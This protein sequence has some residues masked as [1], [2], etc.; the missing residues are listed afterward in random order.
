M[1]KIL[2]IEDEPTLRDELVLILTFEGYD[3]IPAQDGKSGIE[4]A[5]QHLPNLILC[6]VTM[7]RLDG[8]AVFTQLRNAPETRNIP[9]VLMT[10]RATDEDLRQGNALGVDGYITK[11][12]RHQ[13]FMGMIEMQLAR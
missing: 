8:Y 6:D 9:F 4:L 2:V 1:T 7:P 5:S 12:F 13:D 3:A 11:P 10:A